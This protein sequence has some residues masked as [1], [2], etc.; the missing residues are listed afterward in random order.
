MSNVFCSNCGKKH[1]LST[2]FCDS[3]GQS[4]KSLNSTKTSQEQPK[5]SNRQPDFQPYI[6]GQ[7]NDSIAADHYDH[8]PRN[9]LKLDFEIR[10]MEYANAKETIGDVFKQG[11]I[12]GPGIV[13]R[14][15]YNPAFGKDP[16]QDAQSIMQEGKAVN[17]EQKQ[18]GF[19]STDVN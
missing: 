6:V 5:Q 2:N 7:D 10:G 17:P 14:R 3:C 11:E 13:E 4:L 15:D 1:L 19:K 8:V 9:I 12:M 18:K 16:K